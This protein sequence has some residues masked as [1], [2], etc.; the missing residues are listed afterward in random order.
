M[1]NGEVFHVKREKTRYPGVTIYTAKN[2]EKTFYITYR[3]S[4]RLIEEPAGR[5]SHGM[6][7][8]K[9]AQRR[10]DRL[11][12]DTATN[13]E[14]RAQTAVQEAEG[15]PT[16]AD[17]WAAYLKYKGAYRARYAESNFVKNH[18]APSFG[19]RTFDSI[20][21]LDLDAAINALL[22]NGKRRTA[23]LLGSL[24][25]RLSRF[26]VKKRL[27]PG[28]TF[29]VELPRQNPGV[30]AFLTTEQITR[31]KQVC[32]TYPDRLSACAVMFCLATG[33]RSGA[34]LRLEWGDL[35]VEAGRIRLRDPKGGD[36]GD[37]DYTALSA[38]AIKYL[39]LIRAR[40]KRVFGGCNVKK[41]WLKIR[42]A[43]DVAIR[44]HDL[45]HG[46][47]TL[48]IAA[49]VDMYTLQRLLTHR[50][51]K[52]TQRYAHLQDSQL[53]MAADKVGGLIK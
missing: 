8:A 19:A 35:D 36:V 17:V 28:L 24:M 5:A 21:P 37:S 42:A 47:S 10:G 49:G 6:T 9:A 32:E 13:T 18:I 31:L 1:S 40:E 34:M 14:T 25:R 39:P 4:G 43:A 50:D 45:R 3:K 26:A 44:F 41:A 7:A 15:E 52:M 51:P 38:T 53:K 12:G 16:V 2:G 11:R 48:A 46:F 20:A 33:I 30:T 23:H 22:K 27:C 29:E